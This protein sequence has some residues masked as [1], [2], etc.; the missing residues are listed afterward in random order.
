M[1]YSNKNNINISKMTLGTVQLG[2]NYG[3]NNNSGM[4]TE[5]QSYD[6]LTAA[7]NGGVTVLD[8]SDDYGKSEQIIGQFIKNNPD[9]QFQICTKFNVAKD[10]KDVYGALEAFAEKS[11]KKLSID[12]IPIF[13]SHTEKNYFDHGSKLTEALVKLKERGFIKNTGISLSTKDCA[14]D[15][16]DCG[17]FDAVQL[18]MNILDNKLILDGTIEKMHKS[19]ISVFVRS[20]YLQGLFFKNKADLKDTKLSAAIPYLEKIEEIANDENMTIGELALAFIRD[21]VG[22]DSLVIGSESVKQVED[23]LKLF[24]THKLSDTTMN[25]IFE[26][27]SNVDQF[28]VSPWLWNK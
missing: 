8:T 15:I 2:M 21:S 4:P 28:V 6:I 12:C 20:V 5:Q 24:S 26:S 25:K 7:Y 23:N 3:V 9:K 22:V 19:G 13:M 1:E 10:E 11:L 27:F 16:I 17:A 14:N 18:P